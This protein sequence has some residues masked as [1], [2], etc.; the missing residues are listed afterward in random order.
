MCKNTE[1]LVSKM[2]FLRFAFAV[3]SEVFSVKYLQKSYLVA[4]IN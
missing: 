4:E 1:S 2:C 3:E